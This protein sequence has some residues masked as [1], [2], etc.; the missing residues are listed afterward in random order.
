MTP[1]EPIVLKSNSLAA[2]ALWTADAIA[3]FAG[4]SPDTVKAWAKIPHI[5]VYKPGG[6][7][8]A[9]KSELLRWLR[10]KAA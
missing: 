9:M 5:P 10:T 4:V 8:F 6:R 2:E 1:Q 7:Y 3:R